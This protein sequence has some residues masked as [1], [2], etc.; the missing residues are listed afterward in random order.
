MRNVVGPI[1]TVL[2]VIACNCLT[3]DALADGISAGR[4]KKIRHVSRITKCAPVD[5]C[6]FAVA[7]PDGTCYSLYG[8]YGPFGGPAYWTRYTYDGWGYRW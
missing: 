7:C 6:G 3:Q 1:V 4:S 2:T 5:R 8:A